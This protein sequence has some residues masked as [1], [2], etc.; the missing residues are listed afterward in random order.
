MRCLASNESGKLAREIIRAH[1][2]LHDDNR[3]LARDA[4]CWRGCDKDDRHGAELLL[5]GAHSAGPCA[6]KQVHVRQDDRW[7]ARA[8]GGYR[9]MLSLGMVKR[10]CARGLRQLGEVICDEGIAFYD[11]SM[12]HPRT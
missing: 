2:L 6:D 1:R 7:L 12:A 5:N 3:G 9:I 10:G 4:V 8:R 11:Q